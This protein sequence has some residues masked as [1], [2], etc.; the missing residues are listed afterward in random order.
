MK[1][2]RVNALLAGILIVA[3]PPATTAQSGTQVDA[4]KATVVGQ[5][6]DATHA[7]D[8]VLSAIETQ[9]PNMRAANPGF[10]PAFWERFVAQARA[11]RSDLIATLVPVYARAFE[12]SELEELL[13]FYNSPVGRKLLEVQPGL[14]RESVQA[15]Q[16]WAARIAAEVRQQLVKE[17]ALQP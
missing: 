15:G 7:A 12:L 4:Q 6:L 13:R 8:Q 11:R 16:A 10:P 17:G 5:L 2:C 9:L 1:R 14:T 3:L